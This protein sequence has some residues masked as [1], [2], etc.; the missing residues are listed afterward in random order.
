MILILL[1]MLGINAWS[2]QTDT[3]VYFNTWDWD[4]D[5]N[6]LS[7]PVIDRGH[8]VGLEDADVGEPE[9]HGQPPP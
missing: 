8:V 3:L 7:D 9:D 6:T 1:I 4:F 2:Q 5:I